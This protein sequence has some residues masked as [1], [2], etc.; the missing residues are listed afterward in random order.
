MGKEIERKFLVNDTGW[1]AGRKPARCIQ[2]YLCLGSGVTARVRRM[3]GKGYITVKGGGKGMARKEF[4]YEIPADEAE[5][6]LREL[7]VRPLIEK[8][9]Y[10]VE[11]RGLVWEVDVFLGENS[12]LV[13]AEVELESEGQE[14]DLPDW[15]GREV[16]GD[17]RY[18]NA[19][20]VRNPYCRWKE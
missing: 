15:A 4:E 3:A 17:P 6:M 16:T 12:G 5:E 2:G 14:V 7:C 9:R 20:L 8:D 13:I 19:Q 10:E 18:F 11:H 1:L